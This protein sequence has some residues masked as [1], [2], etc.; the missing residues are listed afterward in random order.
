MSSVRLPTNTILDVTHAAA[1]VLG[2][3]ILTTV[4]SGRD[5][6]CVYLVSWKL[7]VVTL[8]SGNNNRSLLFI[9]THT[10]LQ[11]FVK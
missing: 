3:Y 8:V 4:M 11:S 7:G 2:D 1:D 6:C 5:V 9:P 10:D